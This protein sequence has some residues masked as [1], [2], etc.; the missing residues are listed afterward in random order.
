MALAVRAMMGLNLPASRR[1]IWRVASYPSM[2]CI[3]QSIRMASHGCILASSTAEAPS[4][5]TTQLRPFFLEQQFDDTL[6]DAVV[7][8]DQHR[9]G[10]GRGAR[11]ATANG[12]VRGGALRGAG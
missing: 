10:K 2:P 9:T 5:T 6:I 3:W 7:C 11:E 1:R 4:V 12:N 8:D